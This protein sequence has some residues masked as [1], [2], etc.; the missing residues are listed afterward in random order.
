MDFFV[1][2]FP[3]SYL[4]ASEDFMVKAHNYVELSASICS[5]SSSISY[6]NF[7]AHCEVV[8]SDEAIPD[9]R[10]GHAGGSCQ[11]DRVLSQ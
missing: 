1:E 8:G 6:E 2:N 11:M 3:S 5:L 9:D 4:L 7:G 10:I